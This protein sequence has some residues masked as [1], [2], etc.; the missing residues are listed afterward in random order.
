ML[1]TNCLIVDDEPLAHEV[2][3]RYIA[4]IPFLKNVGQ[5]YLATEALTFL[6]TQAVDLVFLDIHM[7][8]L[9]GLDFIRTLQQ[10][11]LII[12]TSAHEA[13]ALESFN[14]EVCDYL[15]KP[16][17]FDRFL[18]AVNRAQ[19]QLDFRRQM[20]V[21]ETKNEG[22]PSLES[23]FIYV[24][25]DKKRVKVVLDE[26]LYFESLGNYVKVWGPQKFLLTPRTL[27]SFEEQLPKDSFIRIHKSFII[28][29]KFIHYLEANMIHLSHGKA[30]P[31]GKNFRHLLTEGL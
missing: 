6:N 22:M 23:S 31:I 1:T 28:N 14:L 19:T 9:N 13:Y 27:I 7:P 29:K 21:T 24:K 25:S 16:F 15:L 18:K 5:C 8:K 20:A 30:L 26:V 10:P 11:P 17:R 4:D 12:I 3:L 2:L